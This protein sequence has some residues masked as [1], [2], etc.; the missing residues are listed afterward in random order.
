[1]KSGLKLLKRFDDSI[2]AHI[3]KTKLLSEGIESVIFDENIMTLNP[4]Y[5]VTVGGVRLMVLHSDYKKA[6]AVMQEGET[7]SVIQCP[8]CDSYE[9]EGPFKTAKTPLSKI[10]LLLSFITFAY[11][12]HFKTTYKCQN[13]TYEFEREDD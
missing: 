11:P 13:C 3:L 5:N 10:G 2:G 8:M 12:F 4:L 1:M 7:T 6:V 9:V